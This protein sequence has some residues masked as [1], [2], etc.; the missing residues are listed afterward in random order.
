MCKVTLLCHCEVLR[1]NLPVKTS[2]PSRS[3]LEAHRHCDPNVIASVLARQS[4][5]NK[6]SSSTRHNDPNVIADL[7]HYR[8]TFSCPFVIAIPMSLRAYSRGN[9][10]VINFPSPTVILT[11]RSEWKNLPPPIIA[12]K[13]GPLV[14]EGVNLKPLNTKKEPCALHRAQIVKKGGLLIV[15]GLPT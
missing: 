12:A 1:G 13:R 15:G 8:F 11:E 2:T 5:C 4:T 7:N 3:L 9:L 6:L 10:P 14:P